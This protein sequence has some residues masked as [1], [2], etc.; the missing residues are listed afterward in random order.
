V[1]SGRQPGLNA[2]H[3]AVSPDA[4]LK[5]CAFTSRQ[6]LAALYPLMADAPQRAAS[7]TDNAKAFC[8]SSDC[9][10][11]ENHPSPAPQTLVPATF[12]APMTKT[13]AQMVSTSGAAGLEV[14]S[15]GRC[16]ASIVLGG[17]DMKI[18]E[19][20]LEASVAARATAVRRA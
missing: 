16:G 3:A 19:Q 1:E 18:Q 13:L 11:S 14:Q 7:P 4:Q 15:T 10:Q 20:P 2:W 17:L 5:F 9:A 6:R 8:F 12:I